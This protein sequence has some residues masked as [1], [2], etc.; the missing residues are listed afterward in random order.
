MA[1]KVV[2]RVHKPRNRKAQ[3]A[4]LINIGAI[5]RRLGR[6]ER[7]MKVVTGGKID[8]DALVQ[9]IEDTAR[10]IVKEEIQIAIRQVMES[11]AAQQSH[12]QDQ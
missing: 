2:K 6:L 4:T 10:R 1:K 5:K 3:D 7:D 12:L 9:T 8:C 11:S